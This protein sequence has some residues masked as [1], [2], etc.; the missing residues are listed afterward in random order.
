MSVLDELIREVAADPASIGLIVHGSRAARVDGPE[1]DFDLVRVVTD[2]SY[3][4]RRDREELRERRPGPPKAD[5]SFSGSS[6]PRQN[7]LPLLSV[8][9]TAVNPDTL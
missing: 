4:A 3:A 6:V 8:T 1:S 7:L 9:A 2:E 5:K